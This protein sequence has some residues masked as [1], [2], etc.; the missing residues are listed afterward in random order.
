MKILVKAK[1]GA[2][3]ERVEQIDGQTFRV[4]VKEPPVKGQANEAILRVVAAYLG[5]SRARVRITSGHTSRSK[6]IEIL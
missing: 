2:R 5:V 4:S 6:V 1:P 3:E